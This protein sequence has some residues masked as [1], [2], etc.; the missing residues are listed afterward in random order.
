[1]SIRG[2]LAP[3]TKATYAAGPKRFTQFCDEWGIDEEGRMP[4][5]YPLLCA[6]IAE[7]KGKQA[8][9]TIRS[10]LSGLRSWHIINHA[11][12]YGDDEWVHLARI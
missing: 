1:M 2:A 10:W 7:H 12:W 8:G 4:A 9:G 11:P 3:N 5:S 6:F